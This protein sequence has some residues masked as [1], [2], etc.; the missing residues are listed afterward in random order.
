M[1]HKH[2]QKNLSGS[3]VPCEQRMVYSLDGGK[4]WINQHSYDIL[5]SMYKLMEKERVI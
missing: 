1:V 4:T 3:H 2:L 5:I